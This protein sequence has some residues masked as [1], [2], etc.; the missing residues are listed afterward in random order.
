MMGDY[1]RLVVSL[2]AC[3]GELGWWMGNF[4]MWVVNPVTC[5]SGLGSVGGGGTQTKNCA[6]CTGS[7][8][9]DIFRL[10]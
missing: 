9:K 7:F 10:V 4:L 8:D 5:A 3:N 1:S 2:A 6:L